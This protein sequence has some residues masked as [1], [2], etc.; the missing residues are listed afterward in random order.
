MKNERICKVAPSM[1]SCNF[2]DVAKGVEQINISG[3]DIIHLD[4]MDGQFVPNISF[5]PKFIKDMRPLSSLP[6]DTHLMVQQPEHLIPSFVDAGSDIITVHA[7]ATVHLHKAIGLIH[8]HGI[9]AGISIVP[10]T[11]VSSLFLMLEEI[12][13]VLI[14]SVNPGFGG[15]SFIDFSYDKIKEL[16]QFREKHNLNFQI[17][18]DG[19]IITHNAEK[20]FEAGADILVMGTTFFHSE[21]QKELVSSMHN[22]K[23]T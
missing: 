11:S 19:G 17:S 1:L 8:Q 4:V 2:T 10:S 21:D 15:Q 9:Q 3:A 12:D 5:G 20:V 23:R 14:M 18:V 13:L 7:E 22:L 16:A 6:F